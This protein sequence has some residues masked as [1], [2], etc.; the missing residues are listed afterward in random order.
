MA[1]SLQRSVACLRKAQ[2]KT[3]R[4]GLQPRTHSLAGT[5]AQHTVNQQLPVLNKT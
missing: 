2:G 4:E 5:V 3:G 1:G